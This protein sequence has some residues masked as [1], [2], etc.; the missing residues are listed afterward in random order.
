MINNMSLKD[1]ITLYYQ[2]ENV[3]IDD[4]NY[5]MFIDYS[6]KFEKLNEIFG[7]YK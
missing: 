6:Y 1:F 3:D 2:N 5:D 7:A 4:F